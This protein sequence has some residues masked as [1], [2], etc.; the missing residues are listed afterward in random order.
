MRR[1][2]TTALRAVIYSALVVVVPTVVFLVAMTAFSAGVRFGQYHWY[3]A[4][5]YAYAAANGFATLIALAWFT[6]K[7]YRREILS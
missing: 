1:S 5:V 6:K 7:L 4:A 2:A 3:D